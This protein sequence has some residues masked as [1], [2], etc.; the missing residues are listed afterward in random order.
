VVGATSAWRAADSRTWSGLRKRTPTQKTVSAPIVA[1]QVKE[2][3]GIQPGCWNAPSMP[4]KGATAFRMTMF[5]W[6]TTTVCGQARRNRDDVPAS[7]PRRSVNIPMR[8]TRAWAQNESG[9]SEYDWDDSQTWIRHLG[10][11]ESAGDDDHEHG[12][13]DREPARGLDVVDLALA[14]NPSDVQSF[15]APVARALSAA[16]NE[17]MAVAKMPASTRPRTPTGMTLRIYEPKTSAV[18]CGW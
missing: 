5:S 2:T 18:A 4:N 6:P 10:I 16:E 1:H 3:S 11:G 9:D 13:E 12:E 14:A 7:D 8:N 15:V 17:P